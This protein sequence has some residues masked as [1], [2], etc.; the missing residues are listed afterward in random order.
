[1]EGV[2]LVMSH[3]TFKVA[4][5]CLG[6]CGTLW[7]GSNPHLIPWP[8]E[9]K[10]GHTTL[11]IQGETAI[12]GIQENPQAFHSLTESLKAHGIP[13]STDTQKA[14]TLI[15]LGKE[16]SQSLQ[17]QLKDRMK[18]LPQEGYCLEISPWGK[19]T[20][21]LLSGNQ[22]IGTYYA[23]QTFD[24]L[25][26]EGPRQK[27]V[28]IRDYPGFALERGYG[29]YFYGL[30]WTPEER[31]A[32]IKFMGQMKMNFFMYSPKD[33]PYNRDRWR[34]DYPPEFINRLRD[35]LEVAKDNFVTFS[36]AMNPGLSIK[37]SDDSEFSI[38]M[39]KYQQAW[40]L[41]IR[42]YSL[43][44]DDI[45]NA[46]RHPEDA[47]KFKNQGEAHAYLT[48]RVYRALKAKDSNIGFSMCGM[49][50]Y[51]AQPDDY[52]Y[53][54]GD[55]LD[56]EISCM[57]TG[58]DVVDSFISIDEVYL[59]A[60]GIKRKPFISDNYPVND[61]ATTRLFMGPLTGR[62]NDL[63]Y[64]V[65]N[66]FLENPM[67]QEEASKIG[68]ACS[69]DY[70][71]NPYKYD[72]ERSFENAL[73]Q[74][75]GR[76]GYPALR[77]FCENNRSSVMEKRESIEMTRLILDYFEKPT[78]SNYLKLH[79]YL[80]RLSTLE[81][82]LN[83]T[84]DNKKLLQ[85]IHPWVLKL[86]AYGNAGVK[87]LELIHNG[88]K[89]Q[90]DKAW[91]L[92]QDLKIATGKAQDI[93]LIVCEGGTMERLIVR[94]TL[95]GEGL[96]ANR[97]TPAA[98]YTRQTILLD[99]QWNFIDHLSDG[100]IESAFRPNRSLVKGDYVRVN[101]PGIR[102]VNE[103]NVSF[104]TPQAPTEFIYYGELEYSTD[105]E[106]WK[107]LGDVR[108][109]DIHW[110]NETPIQMKAVQIR[111]TED[112]KF[113]PRLKEFSVV[114]AYL[115]HVSGNFPGLTPES[116]KALY[117]GHITTVYNSGKPPAKDQF[118]TLD[119]SQH[120]LAAKS[121][122]LYMDPANFLKKPLIKVKT[123]RRSLSLTPTAGTS[124]IECQLPGEKVISVT[125]SSEISQDT[126]IMIYEIVLT[127]L[128]NKGY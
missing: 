111:V 23:V 55:N 60:S 76:K 85:E 22:P 3:H 81:S 25:L 18:N 126:P 56:P 99:G 14:K 27:A 44:I 17:P 87:A 121:L 54:L 115:P 104:A 42:N 67:N 8:R 109:P 2:S 53:S 105:M 95:T 94:A 101:L 65:Y 79:S 106:N 29:E 36:F 24:Q 37:Y 30:P 123:E 103:I 7:A 108:Y 119:Y 128:Q 28:Q 19:R 74:V 92:Y 117:D 62:P 31:M 13:Y 73:Y 38:L 78:D 1:M 116:G 6:L 61:F 86:Q 100:N 63:I 68:L 4:I 71:W 45:G 20:L 88:P 124:A 50:Y 64:H 122:I 97:L 118:I 26:N 43:Q 72:P 90:A 84:I 9:I 47:V 46:V 89:M 69:A 82:D 75:A 51:I 66:G 11:N 35:T 80:T 114:P 127:D 110:S 21:V 83:Q 34:E 93:P 40:D 120:P 125:L 48:N 91:T 59:F 10:W 39:H 12:L 58:G 77:L 70:A 98:T 5:A 102:P 52:T 113:T 49:M 33:D 32:S 15:I 112:Q 96:H 107:T 16:L 41:G 57:W